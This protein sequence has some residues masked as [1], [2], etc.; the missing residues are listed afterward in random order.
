MGKQLVHNL[1]GDCEN[2]LDF[3]ESDLDPGEVETERR[4]QNFIPLHTIDLA[5]WM[6][7]DEKGAE[8]SYLLKKELTKADLSVG[9]FLADCL[10]VHMAILCYGAVCNTNKKKYLAVAR[11]SHRYI[12]WIGKQSNPNFIHFESL[13]DAEVAA[14]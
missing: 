7:D 1:A 11:Q 8:L 3:K 6:C 9:T 14:V 12:K 13:V 2:P 5:A 4:Y 10:E